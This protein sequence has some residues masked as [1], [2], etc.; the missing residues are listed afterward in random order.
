M[1]ARLLEAAVD[2]RVASPKTLVYFTYQGGLRSQRHKN[3]DP[4]VAALPHIVPTLA[5][6]AHLPRTQ[7]PGSAGVSFGRMTHNLVGAIQSAAQRYELPLPGCLRET[8]LLPEGRNDIPT[9][10]SRDPHPYPLKPRAAP[11]QWSGGGWCSF[12][13]GALHPL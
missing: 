9:C 11:P 1:V 4:S 5:P 3:T 2:E 12:V 13:V 6:G 8:G 7:V 10:K